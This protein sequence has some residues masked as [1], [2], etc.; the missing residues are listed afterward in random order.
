VNA[1]SAGAESATSG[2]LQRIAAFLEHDFHQ[3]KWK[4]PPKRN[5]H[6]AG[7]GKHGGPSCQPPLG[8]GAITGQVNL[9]DVP[10][11]ASTE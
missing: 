4:A 8:L 1:I 7:G 9:R 10:V 5:R 3:R 2:Q 6:P 11:T